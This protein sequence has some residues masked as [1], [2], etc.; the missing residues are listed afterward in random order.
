MFFLKVDFLCLQVLPKLRN[1]TE[2]E[3]DIQGMEKA[4]DVNKITKQTLHYEDEYPILKKLKFLVIQAFDPRLKEAI[5]NNKN[6]LQHLVIR[7]SWNHCGLDMHMR[8][9]QKE[10]LYQFYKGVSLK[11]IVIDDTS[12]FGERLDCLLHVK[13]IKIENWKLEES[14]V[15]LKSLEKLIESSCELRSLEYTGVGV[16]RARDLLEKYN[17]KT[18]TNTSVMTINTDCDERYQ[19]CLA[20]A[21]YRGSEVGAWKDLLPKIGK[22]LCFMTD[23]PRITKKTKI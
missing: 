16:T 3:G 8:N 2:I 19:I 6:T 9:Q 15:F 21:K 10:E 4:M 17:F 11:S 13:H 7:E 1:V 23:N 5:G 14:E 18:K 20:I 22:M 12:S